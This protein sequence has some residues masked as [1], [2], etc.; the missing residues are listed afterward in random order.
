MKKLISLRVRGYGNS[1]RRIPANHLFIARRPYFKLRRY[2]V[3]P[4]LTFIGIAQNG[5]D[6]HRGIN[7]GMNGGESP[8]ITKS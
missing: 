7:F 5:R 2:L 8:K 1:K 3:E 4:F 6:P